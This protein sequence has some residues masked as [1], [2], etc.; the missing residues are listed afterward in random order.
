MLALRS[1]GGGFMCGGNTFGAK[2]DVCDFSG[3]PDDR[4]P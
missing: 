3:E 1:S 4:I 2:N